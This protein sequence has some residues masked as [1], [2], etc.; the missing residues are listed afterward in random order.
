MAIPQIFR[1][2]PELE[3]QTIAA[4]L[5][6]WLPGTSWGEIRRLMRS[7]HVMISGNLCVD[8]GRRL[9][10]QDV[11]KILPESAAPAPREQ[12]VH[13]RHLDEHV[14][15]VEKPAGLTSN[16][17][18]EERNWSA[19]R[20]QMQPTLDELLSRVV[21]KLDTRRRGKGV[22]V[23]VRAVHRLDRDTSGLMVFA[24]T[25][26]AER[27][28]AEQFRHHTTHRRYLAI[29]EG[30]IE[31]Q[32]ISTK[33]VRDRGDGHR[34]STT[35]PDVGKQAVTHVRPLEQLAGGKYTLIECRLKTGRTH[36]IRIHLSEL[37]HTVCGEKIYRRSMG[38]RPTIDKSGAPR[39]A[40]HA[41]ELGFEHPQS[42]EQ[43]RFT[44]PFPRDLREFLEAL[45]GN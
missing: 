18:R 10:L 11:V 44:M 45:R 36:Q 38:G 31:A 30:A 12:D 21:S 5:R 4:A 29:V 6:R 22:P 16:R 41:A 8:A 20:R 14:V 33:L 37:G 19:H 43:L 40:L 27:H 26:K 23:P 3:N 7:R 1:V 13:V 17:H 24:R 25:A 35:Q 9:K 39:L 28:L 2:L 42:S 15:V 34:G 32:T